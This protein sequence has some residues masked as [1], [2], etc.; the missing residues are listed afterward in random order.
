[1]EWDDP[2]AFVLGWA[3]HP[4]PSIHPNPTPTAIPRQVTRKA[5]GKTYAIKRV[6]LEGLEQQDLAMTLNEVR[7]GGA[8]QPALIPLLDPPDL[9]P[10]LFRFHPLAR[11]NPQIRLL[12]SFQHPRIVGL[13]ETFLEGGALSPSPSATP[14]HL[15]VVMEYC[16]FQDLERKIRRYKTR[17]ERVDERVLWVYLVQTLEALAALHSLKI[18]HRGMFVSDG[19]R[20]ATLNTHTRTHTHTYPTTHQPNREQT[21]SR[22]TFCWTRRGTPSWGT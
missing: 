11:S 19:G 9:N 1:M 13:H 12:A 4:S 21:S 22:P 17:G 16:G 20:Q 7:G 8:I 2:R 18:L 15:C 6:K 3:S 5:D 10:L 14:L